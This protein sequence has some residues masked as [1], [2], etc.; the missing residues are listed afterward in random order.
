MWLI[1]IRESSTTTVSWW[2][3][4]A[5]SVAEQEWFNAWANFI[6]ENED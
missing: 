6:Y 5:P 1:S 2:N 4:I 3:Y